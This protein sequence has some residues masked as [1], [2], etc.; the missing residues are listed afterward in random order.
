MTLIACAAC[1]RHV[2]STELV[3]PFCGTARD[4]AEPSEAPPSRAPTRAGVMVGVAI[5]AFA[6]SSALL[7]SAC[8]AYG[9]PIYHEDAGTDAG[10]P[11]AH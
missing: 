1:T 2:R 10:A 3:C 9:G 11:D 6:L 5:G 4:A 7:G 8:A